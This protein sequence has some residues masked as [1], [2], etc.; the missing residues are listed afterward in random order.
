VSHL[1]NNFVR[2]QMF[3][4]VFNVIS[5]KMNSAAASQTKGDQLNL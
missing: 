5:T 2:Q 4:S 3:S 1:A